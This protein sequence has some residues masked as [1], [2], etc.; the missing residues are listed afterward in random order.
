M[1]ELRTRTEEIEGGGICLI[2]LIC[3]SVS[4]WAM[5][6]ICNIC[7]IFKYLLEDHVNLTVVKKCK[8]REKFAGGCWKNIKNIVWDPCVI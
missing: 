6:F 1:Y 2:C 7:N 4:S 3:L 8:K 5:T